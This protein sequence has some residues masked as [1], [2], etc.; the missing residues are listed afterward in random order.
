MSKISTLY[1]KIVSVLSA[2][3]LSSNGY[4]RLPNIIEVEKNPA[5]F[6]RKGYGFSYSGASS[7]VE[8]YSSYSTNHLFQFAFTRE[9]AQLEGEFSDY[10]T[11]F[12]GIL[13]DIK[14]LKDAFYNQNGL[15]LYGTLEISQIQDESGVTFVSIGEGIIATASVDI[16]FRLK[17]NIS[18]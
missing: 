4:Y 15:N 17:E 6:L 3:Y 1:D 10:D 12:K 7:E 9:I 13:E 14:L 8:E 18:C 2:T 5:G 11:E 16:V